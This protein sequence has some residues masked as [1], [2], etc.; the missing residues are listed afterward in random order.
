MAT[1]HGHLP[2][3]DGNTEDWTVYTE[4]LK[5][6]FIANDIADDTKQRSLLLSVCGVSTFKL[7][8][9]LLPG[10]QLGKK[11][12]AEIA[13]LVQEHFHPQPSEIVSRFNFNSSAHRHGESTAAFVARLRHLAAH[14]NYGESLDSMLRDRL[15][16]GIGDERLQRRLLREKELTFIKAFELCQV[17]ESAESN[18]KLLNKPEAVHFHPRS[19]REQRQPIRTT[20][21]CYRCGGAHTPSSCRFKDSQCNFCQKKGHIAKVCRSRIRQQQS[22]QLQPV[23]TN[24]T[25][26]GLHEIAIAQQTTSRVT[27]TTQTPA[28]PPNRILTAPHS[29]W[30]TPCFKLPPQGWR[31][32][33][34]L[35]LPTAP[36]YTWKLT[37][38]PRCLLSAKPHTDGCGQS[39][40]PSYCP[41]PSDCARTRGRG[42]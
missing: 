8:Q 30:S 6:Y 1:F 41:R 28:T 37:W 40:R 4:R 13:T 34:Y 5:H 2:E 3:Y 7:I 22:Q 21:Q 33:A 25:A 10:D 19:D 12:F 18:A 29:L 11:K 27:P 38:E 35:S 26:G 16:C 17:Q 14:C 15:V 23:A 42:S 20:E 32:F 24:K 9:S 39:T 31:R 36:A